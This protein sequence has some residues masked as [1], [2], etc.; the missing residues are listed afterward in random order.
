[1]P[2][3]DVLRKK[4]PRLEKDDWV[5]S[6]HNRACANIIVWGMPKSLSTL[7]VRGKL[8]DIGLVSVARGNVRWEGDHIRVVLKPKDSRGITKEVVTRIS[9]CLRKIGCRCVLDQVSIAQQQVELDVQCV[10]RFEPLSSDD[11]CVDVIAVE[12]KIK[13]VTGNKCE[14]KLR[15]G[16]WNFAGLCSERKQK[17]VGQVLEKLN[18]DVVA[19]QESWERDGS[20]VSVDGYKWFGK[21]RNNQKSLRG[22]GGVGF[23]VRECLVDELLVRLGM[24][25]VCG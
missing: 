22:E 3:R 20:V 7:E 16:T 25:R 1:M 19:G 10:N 24:R 6:C 8:S 14:R 5:V 2:R 15:I 12:E 23:L 17:E 13:A 11:E 21:P 18:L 4:D 9:A